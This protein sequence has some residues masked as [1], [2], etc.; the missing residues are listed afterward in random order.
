VTIE[1]NNIYI[2][3]IEDSDV[4]FSNGTTNNL[5]SWTTKRIMNGTF[6]KPTI[7]ANANGEIRIL[8][9]NA[10]GSST[11]NNITLSNSSDY[12][13]TWGNMTLHSGGYAYPSIADDLYSN[14]TNKLHYVF[15]NYSGG[16]FYANLTIPYTPPEPPPNGAPINC[17]Y[18]GANYWINCSSSCNLNTYQEITGNVYM[19][20]SGIAT[21]TNV[22]NFTSSNQY[23]NIGSGCEMSIGSGGD[24]T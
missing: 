2:A 16:L 12:G 9:Q 14:T 20:G 23:I 6:Y 1:G 19:V 24:I 17:T 13:R 10:I 21:L 4:Y 3:H 18:S 15:S 7:G 5:S 22:W 11:G 8:Y